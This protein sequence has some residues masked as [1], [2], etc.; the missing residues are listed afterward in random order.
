LILTYG[1]YFVFFWTFFGTT[2]GGFIIGIRLVDSK[3]NRPSIFRA[4]FRFV[5]EFMI[6][7]L[8]FIGSLWILFTSRKQAWYDSIAGTYVIYNWAAKPEE[9]H[10]RRGLIA[11]YTLPKP[12]VK[13]E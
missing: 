3:G 13:E 4:L 10:V 9:R 6:P 2:I 1:I 7:I 11:G 12:T 5:I 8:L